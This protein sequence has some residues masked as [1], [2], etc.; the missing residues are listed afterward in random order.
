[1]LLKEP[2]EWVNQSM[3]MQNYLQNKTNKNVHIQRN[4]YEFVGRF[5]YQKHISEHTPLCVSNAFDWYTWRDQNNTDKFSI[6]KLV[7]KWKPHP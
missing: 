4:A 5:D 3:Q 7:C 2:K 1:M 6:K